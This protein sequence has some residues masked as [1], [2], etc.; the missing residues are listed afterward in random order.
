VALFRQ[1]ILCLGEG[2]KQ[3]DDDERES[4]TRHE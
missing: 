3:S 4:L 1:L 2:R